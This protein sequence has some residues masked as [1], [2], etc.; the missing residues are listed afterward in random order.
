MGLVRVANLRRCE[1]VSAN[2]RPSQP[3]ECAWGHWWAAPFSRAGH[4]FPP[5]T[6]AGLL[7]NTFWLGYNPI[8]IIIDGTV[9]AGVPIFSS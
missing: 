8:I 1:L 4:Q 5:E 6:M 3:P 2:P 9:Y 7:C